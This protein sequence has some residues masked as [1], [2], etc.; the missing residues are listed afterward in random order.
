[1]PRCEAPSISMTSRDEPV[2][3]SWHELQLL[4]VSLCGDRFLQFKALAKIRASVVLPVPCEPQ[5]RYACAILPLLRAFLSVWTMGSCPNTSIN[6]WGR[7]FL[8]KT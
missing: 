1:M 5:K 8:A 6:V 4:Q 3:I 7:Y 2:V